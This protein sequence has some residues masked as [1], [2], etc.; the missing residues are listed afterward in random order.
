MRLYDELADWWPLLSPAVDYED[1]AREVAELLRR[2]TDGE[3]RT[4]L[5]LGCGGGSLARWLRG[6]FE[7]TLTD[8][9]ER[10]LEVSRA[11][12]PACEHRV[13][14]MRTLFLDRTFDAVLV[15][16]AVMYATSRTELRSVFTTARR[17]LRPGGGL[18]AMPDFL[19]ETF[20]PGIDAGGHDVKDGRGLRYLEWKFDPDPDDETVEVAYAFLLRDADG[21]T[22]VEHDRHRVGCFMRATWIDV[23]ADLGFDPVG[24][25]ESAGRPVF[26]ATRR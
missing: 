18:V 7:L 21:S 10:M 19:A 9:S 12:N 14:D 16:D 6:S 5:E 13:G 24:C 26:L 22:S 3:V 2:S 4:V 17:H 25:V 8:R 23:L 20:E 15:H 1:E 11:I